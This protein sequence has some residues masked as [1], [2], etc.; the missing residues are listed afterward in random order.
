[1]LIQILGYRIVGNC[2]DKGMTLATSIPDRAFLTIDSGFPL[3]TLE[4]SQEKGQ[5][6][7]YSY[8]STKAP[9]LLHET[10]WL[11]VRRKR[12]SSNLVDLLVREPETAR[13]Y[14]A[15]ARNDSETNAALQRSPGLAKLAALAPVLDF[16]GSQI[17]VRGGK[18]LVPGGAAAEGQWKELAGASPEK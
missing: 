17:L 15:M 6:F 4:E 16:Y 5:P 3:M 1:M 8:P 2:G 9:V 11:N 10:D 13:L 7:N 12:T 18:V 14:W